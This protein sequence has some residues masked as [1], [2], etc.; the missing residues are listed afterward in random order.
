[1]STEEAP[2]PVHGQLDWKSKSKSDYLDDPATGLPML[3]ALTHFRPSDVSDLEE[4]VNEIYR[5]AANP[6]YVEETTSEE[7]E[8]FWNLALLEFC[9]RTATAQRWE[10][11]ALDAFNGILQFSFPGKLGW[12]DVCHPGLNLLKR[13]CQEYPDR[14]REPADAAIAFYHNDCVRIGET[15]VI[16]FLAYLRD[17]YPGA[18]IQIPRRQERQGPAPAA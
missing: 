18:G 12:G 11:L 10:E 8:Y 4:L 3:M 9:Y 17:A 6:T 13:L 5:R 1:M 16:L 2:Q 7:N 15:E 14:A